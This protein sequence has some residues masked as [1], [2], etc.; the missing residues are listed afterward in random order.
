MH[1]AIGETTP[2]VWS[3]VVQNTSTGQTFSMTTPYSST[4]ATAE[5]IEETP[6]VLQNSGAVSVGPMPSLSVVQF[7]GSS[8]NN[9]PAGLVASE[10]M[11]LVDTNGAPLA[12]PS[13]PTNDA[14]HDCTYS[15]TCS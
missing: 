1:V 4:Y 8:T 14:F 5:W 10:E 3:I 6:V 15:A 9:G 2:S 12:T 11:Q 13:V 7:S